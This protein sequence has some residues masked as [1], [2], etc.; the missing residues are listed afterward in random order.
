MGRQWHVKE[1]ERRVKGRGEGDAINYGSSL[2][3]ILQLNLG[4]MAG[5]T[6]TRPPLLPPPRMLC[7]GCECQ[8]DFL[9]SSAWIC[10][11]TALEFVFRRADEYNKHDR[12][13]DSGKKQ[14]RPSPTHP[15]IIPKLTNHKAHC[16]SIVFCF[17][18][19]FHIQTSVA[20]AEEKH[21]VYS[22]QPA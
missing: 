9:R 20:A 3:Q 18:H 12:R 13:N 2:T 5:G 1:G 16:T 11:V 19:L 6:S 17:V 8:I 10:I 14:A 21:E 7:W 22:M 4:H 15:S